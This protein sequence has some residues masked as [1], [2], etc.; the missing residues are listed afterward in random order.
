[1]PGFRRILVLSLIAACCVQEAFAASPADPPLDTVVVT[2]SPEETRR[3]I[4]TFVSSVTRM[5]GE[6]IGR[7][8]EHICP[9]VVGLSDEQAQFVQSRLI[10][11]QNTVRKLKPEGDKACQPNLF[12]IVSDESEQVLNSWKAR[13]PGMFRWKTREGVSRSNGNGPVR[14]WHNAIMEPSDSAPVLNGAPVNGG[15][16]LCGDTGIPCFKLK[17]SRIES[18][19]AENVRAVVVLVDTRA[20]GVVNLSQLADYIAMVSLSQL[21]LTANVG[22]VNSILKLFAEPRPDAPPMGLTEWDLA[23]LNGL[24]RT[25]YSPMNQRRDIAARMTRA[26]APR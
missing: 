4:Q 22:A 19:A 8:L 6:L 24:Y 12:V 9:M 1:M 2:G 21:D 10:E 25:S 3:Q 15:P 23:F 18:S 13:D 7:W 16:D 17:P 20:A 5:D 14:T 11:V 26:L